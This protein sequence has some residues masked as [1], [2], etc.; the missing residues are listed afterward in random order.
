MYEFMWTVSDCVYV[1][2]FVFITEES[3]PS[4]N[5]C[6]PWIYYTVMK[7][8]GTYWSGK[9]RFK[10]LNLQ[11]IKENIPSPSKSSCLSSKGLLKQNCEEVK[12]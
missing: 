1:L 4:T 10:L 11:Y 8:V 2:I 7:K 3:I 9:C 6:K 5:W 12:L